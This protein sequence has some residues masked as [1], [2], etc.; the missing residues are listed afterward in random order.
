MEDT[1]PLPT[2]SEHQ[3]VDAAIRAL[4]QEAHRLRIIDELFPESEE[5]YRSE[6]YDRRS[7]FLFWCHLDP[8]NQ[9]RTIKIA[10][11]LVHG[12]GS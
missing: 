3:A 12:S 11:R 9:R 8:Q 7:P 2:T 5:G 4:G 6:W 10:R 1:T